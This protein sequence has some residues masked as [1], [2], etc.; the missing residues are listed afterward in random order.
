MI[1]NSYLR[2]RIR[3]KLTSIQTPSLSYPPRVNL[4]IYPFNRQITISK[5]KQKHSL[6]CKREKLLRKNSCNENTIRRI[7]RKRHRKLLYLLSLIRR[8]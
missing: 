6:N 4:R 8:I 7:S 1:K 3:P 2:T 5:N